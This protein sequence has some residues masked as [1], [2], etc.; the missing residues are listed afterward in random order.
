[1]HHGELQCVVVMQQALLAQPELL[2]LRLLAPERP[3]AV[4]RQELRAQLPQEPQE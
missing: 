1:M 4:R 2:A 3:P